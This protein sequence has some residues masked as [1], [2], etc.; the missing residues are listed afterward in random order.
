MAWWLLWD[1]AGWKPRT[2]MPVNPAVVGEDQGS[3]DPTRTGKRLLRSLAKH[4]LIK[5]FDASGP[6]WTIHLFDPLEVEKNVVVHP[7]AEIQPELFE[8]ATPARADEAP[9][10]VPFSFSA[11]VAHDP[12][13]QGTGKGDK[14]AQPE[15]VKGQGSLPCA[16]GSGATPAEEK[17]PQ[18][19]VRLRRQRTPED[20]GEAAK[21]IPGVLGRILDRVEVQEE[22]SRR[23]A[24]AV[25]R[26][27]EDPGFPRW[28]CE[29][30]GRAI[31]VGAYAEGRLQSKLDLLRRRRA[32]WADKHRG[33]QDS[34]GDTPIRRRNFF[35]SC[36]AKSFEDVGLKLYDSPKRPPPTATET[37]PTDPP[38]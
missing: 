13:A 23:I 31:A 6:Q 28:V 37:K 34:E 24:E 20:L 7:P 3:G 10:T 21:A 29:E 4:G 15:G 36:I 22:R 12:P 14:G 1:L 17:F 2:T 30:I 19:A 32:E 38:F 27:I 35:T 25:F 11:G 33:G 26:E 16:G 8:D 18:L 5:I 9:D